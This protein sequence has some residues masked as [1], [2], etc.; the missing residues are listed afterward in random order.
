MGWTAIAK[1]RSFSDF[2]K[3]EHNVI[4][5]AG[6]VD[7]G[8]REGYLSTHASARMLDEATGGKCYSEWRGGDARAIA[9]SA[10]W[11]FDFD[12]EDKWAYWS[13][14]TFLDVCAKNNLTVSFSW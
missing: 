9:D 8:L 7:G 14:R 4:M 12:P 10:N 6:Y 2:K 3:A 1:T 13:A 5:A 11:D